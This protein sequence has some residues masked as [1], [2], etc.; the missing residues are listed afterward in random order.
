MDGAEGRDRPVRRSRRLDR[1]CRERGS[2]GGPRAREPLLRR[3]LRAH[4]GAWGHRREVCGRRRDGGVR[5]SP[6][7]RGRRRA[8]CS[9]GTRDRPERR[10]AAAVCPDRDRVRR[11]GRRGQRVDVRDGGGGKPR[12]A[13][14]ASSATGRDPARACSP[15]PCRWSS[16]GRRR[17]AARGQGATGAAV[18]R[19]SHPRARFDPRRRDALR[20]PSSGAGVARDVFCARGARS[21]RAARDD[22]R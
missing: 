2:G 12:G 10:G 6:R 18:D 3:R 21:P 4:S 13:A 14:A 20:R 1:A 11:S 7:S 5:C 17:R 15:T 19:T 8:C 9:R 22:L 16:R